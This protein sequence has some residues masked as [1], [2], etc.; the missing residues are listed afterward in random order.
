MDRFQNEY[1]IPSARANWHGYEGGVYFVTIC[2]PNRIHYFGEI[3]CACRDV[4]CNV[5]E[6]GTQTDPTDVARNVSTKDRAM[7]SISPQKNTLATV[8]RGIKS[9][10]TKYA[11]DNGIPFTWQTRFYDRIV[12]NQD[13]LN[14]I[15]NYIENNVANWLTDELNQTTNPPLKNV[16]L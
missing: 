7:A 9:S 10:I 12:R 3:L 4:A 13:E 6:I 5:S 11:K 14:C 2:A 1:R 15:G 8:I 16:N